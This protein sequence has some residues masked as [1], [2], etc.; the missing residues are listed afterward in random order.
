MNRRDV[1]SP[2]LLGAAIIVKNEADHLERCLTSLRGVCD[3]VVVVD[4]GSADRSVQ[5][6]ERHGAV[7][8]HY[9]WDGNFSAAR[10]TALDL[11]TAEWVLYIDADEEV[12]PGDIAA[13][14]H[15]LRHADGII[16][17]TVRFAA[18]VGWTPYWEYRLW[19][20]R[21]DIRFRNRIHETHVPDLRR[22]MRTEHL[23]EAR[24]LLSIQHYG[25]EGDQT[26]KHHRN[27]PLLEQQVIDSPRRVYLWN[28]LGQVYDG[29]GMQAEAEAA[30]R[31]G[32]EIVRVDGLKETVDI[33]VYGSLALHLLRN[34]RSARA[35]IDE[36]LALDDDHYTLILADA[37]QRALDGDFEAAVTS[38]DRLISAGT[39]LDHQSLAYNAAI[40]GPW[41]WQLLGESLFE[42]G[43]YQQAAEAFTEAVHHGAPEV[44]MRTKAT[45]CRSLAGSGDELLG[46]Q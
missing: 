36:G 3:Q 37:R 12:Q 35:V 28:H 46:A 8:G 42:L 38:I 10:N 30:W 23:R 39:S 5:V 24:S 15:Q 21:P 19:R 18:R 2:P 31:H 14:H 22:I 33:L 45:L 13:F 16:T 43:R 17:F 44:E 32:V 34:R 7:V 4:T 26:H 9:P 1:V 29:L 40:F 25:Y 27:R 6:A 20:H 41:A 11:L